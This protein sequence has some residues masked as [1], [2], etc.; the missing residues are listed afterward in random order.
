M[1]FLFKIG[2]IVIVVL[3]LVYMG[4]AS[5]CNKKQI[6]ISKQSYITFILNREIELRK[7]YAEKNGRGFSLTESEKKEFKKEELKFYRYCNLNSSG[8][9]CTVETDINLL[10]TTSYS[11]FH[12][13]L[14]VN[15]KYQFDADS[16]KF[17][18]LIKTYA[19]PRGRKLHFE[20]KAYQASIHG[21]NSEFM[22]FNCEQD[23]LAY[24]E[25]DIDVANTLIPK[26]Q[27]TNIQGHIKDSQK[28]SYRFNTFIK[29]EK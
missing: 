13:E 5:F 22:F 28:I 3:L 4:Y 24:V 8:K 27:L 7:L 18:N 14:I 17:F 29:I 2:F 21:W 10:R 26:K 15:I 19:G 16:M 25:E 11:I 12:K 20:E 6:Q 1:K 23:Y 9:Y